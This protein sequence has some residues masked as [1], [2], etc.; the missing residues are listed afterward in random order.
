METKQI[1]VLLEKYYAGESSLE[2]ERQLQEFFQQPRDLGE[3][4]AHRPA[5]LLP[6]VL[7]NEQLPMDFK[8]ELMEQYAAP[9]NGLRLWIPNR[10]T[11]QIA[12]SILL[13]VSSFLLGRIS[14]QKSSIARSC[15]F[16]IR[17]VERIRR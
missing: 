15:Y 14:K 10:Q 4:E 1:K 5:F 17:N 9:A 8:A 6:E 11:L 3:L 7:Q 2:E 12:A 16:H 13:L